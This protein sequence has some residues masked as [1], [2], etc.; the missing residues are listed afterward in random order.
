LTSELLRIINLNAENTL[1][2]ANTP[3]P[4]VAIEMIIPASTSSLVIV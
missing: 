4:E 1:N 2:D 3:G